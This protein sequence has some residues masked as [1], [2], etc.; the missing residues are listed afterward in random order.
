MKVNVEWQGRRKFY[1]I[2]ESAHS[3]IMDANVEAGGEGN[4]I[5]PTEMLLMG[6]AGCSGID[7]VMILEKMRQTVTSFTT[8]VEGVRAATEPR[9]FTDIALVFKL[10]GEINPANVERA[11]RLSMEKYCSVSN[12]L[13]ARFTF[14]YEVNGVRYPE[15][16]FQ[17]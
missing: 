12:S 4:G 10:T 3:V 8:E 13:N 15:A 11:I 9:K 6:L 7:I 14:A 16:G 5:K 17:E 2:G 1:A